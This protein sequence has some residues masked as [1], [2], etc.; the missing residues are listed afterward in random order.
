MK[1]DQKK[2][3]MEANEAFKAFLRIASQMI[4]ENARYLVEETT[5][6]RGAKWY[7]HYCTPEERKNPQKLK[8]LSFTIEERA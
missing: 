6:N 4:P 3:T 2:P 8:H 1:T 7:F 5:G